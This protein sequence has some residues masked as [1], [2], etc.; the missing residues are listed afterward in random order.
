MPV[1][2]QIY[3]ITDQRGLLNSMLSKYD[4]KSNYQFRFFS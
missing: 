1:P 3:I 4:E 2:S